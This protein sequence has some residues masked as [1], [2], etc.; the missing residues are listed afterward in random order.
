MRKK[1]VSGA[2][3]K[4][5]QA[6]S[7]HCK[8]AMLKDTHNLND[9]RKRLQATNLKMLLCNSGPHHYYLYWLYRLWVLHFTVL[10]RQWV[11]NTIKWR[12]SV[13]KVRHIQW[14]CILDLYSMS[15]D[16]FWWW[17]GFI[18]YL[19]FIFSSSIMAQFNYYIKKTFLALDF[20]LFSII[21]C[22]LTASYG[23]NVI[24]SS[25]A[26]TSPLSYLGYHIEIT[27]LT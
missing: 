16:F 27:L 21:T 8:Q 22:N 7:D 6:Q 20:L 12:F 26:A 2:E 10:R 4:W 13:R 17:V 9:A 25:A 19:V 3:V 18:F 11:S 1:T 23:L 15:S 24:K 14:G 5:T